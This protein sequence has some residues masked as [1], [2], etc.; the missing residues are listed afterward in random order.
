MMAARK[1]RWFKQQVLKVPTPCGGVLA[2]PVSLSLGRVEDALDAVSGFAC[3]IA[4]RLRG[5][6]LA[7]VGDPTSG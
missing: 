2:R 4:S 7:G 5:R 1:A 3:Q 6:F